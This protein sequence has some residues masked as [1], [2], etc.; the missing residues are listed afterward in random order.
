MNKKKLQ[1]L[2]SIVELFRALQGPEIQQNQFEQN[3]Q[4][5]KDA[6]EIDFQQRLALLTQE[7]EANQSAANI[8]FE[9][10]RQLNEDQR[11]S[12]M[13]QN[14]AKFSIDEFYRN[15]SEKRASQERADVLTQRGLDREASIKSDRAKTLQTFL[16]IQKPTGNVLEA[17]ITELGLGDAYAKDQAAQESNQR[18]QATDIYKNL[19]ASAARL[20]DWSGVQSEFNN[21]VTKAGIPQKVVDNLDWASLLQG[22]A[23]VQANTSS[24]GSSI[25]DYTSPALMYKLIEHLL[26]L[27]PNRRQD[28]IE[29]GRFTPDAT[30]TI[31]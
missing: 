16:E 9:R 21:Q 13:T 22:E 12:E 23:P 10:Q 17:I 15:E 28:T 2:M 26:K 3:L 4:A 19:S 30:A 31:F 29:Q 18:A 6:A 27:Q 7:R 1:E 24:S 20:K 25:L 8:A 14:Q 11:L 5:Q